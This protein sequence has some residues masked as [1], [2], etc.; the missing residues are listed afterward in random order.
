MRSNTVLDQTEIQR[1]FRKCCSG[2][3]KLGINLE[4]IRAKFRAHVFWFASK[5]PLTNSRGAMLTGHLLEITSKVETERIENQFYISVYGERQTTKVIS[6]CF[7]VF[8][9]CSFAIV[10]I[11]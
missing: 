2:Q 4:K 1:F 7:S 9:F 11:K 10:Y 8:M 6:Y 5:T 3:T